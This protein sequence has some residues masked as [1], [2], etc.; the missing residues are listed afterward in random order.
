MDRKRQK[1]VT[2]KSKERNEKQIGYSWWIRTLAY[3]RRC[4]SVARS[5][6]KTS[7]PSPETQETE[8]IGVNNMLTILLWTNSTSFLDLTPNGF[9]PKSGPRI[10]VC[11]SCFVDR[12]TWLGQRSHCIIYLDRCGSEK[13]RSTNSANVRGYCE[14]VR[15]GAVA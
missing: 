8:M 11:I 7:I 2:N 3:L 15:F 12:N 10:N 1:Y 13:I 9:N 4:G 6:R 14:H 5:S